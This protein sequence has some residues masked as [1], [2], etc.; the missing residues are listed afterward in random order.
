MVKNKDRWSALSMKERADLIKL[1]VSN[2]ITS[3]SNI[4]KDYNS[5]AP[6]GPIETGKKTMLDP[7]KIVHNVPAREW[8]PYTLNENYEL[9]E[10]DGTS[11]GRALFQYLGNKGKGADNIE[12]AKQIISDFEK[13]IKGNP[14]YN[15]VLDPNYESYVDAIH[16]L[17]HVEGLKK[18]LGLPYNTK[19]IVESNYK[20]TRLQGTD[21]KTYKFTSSMQP[22]Y[23]DEV[24][25]DMLIGEHSKRQYE[26]QTLN[27]FTAYRDR[28]N[29]GDFISIYDEWDYNPAVRG[30]NKKFNKVIDILTGG[31]P[32][33]VYDR[34]Y[35]DDYFNI[36]EEARGNP[37]ITPAVVTAESKKS[38]GGKLNRFDIGGPTREMTPSEATA[39][40]KTLNNSQY[41]LAV[42]NSPDDPAYLSTDILEPAIVKAFNSEED[43]NRYYGEQFGKKV[44][45]EGMN[46]AAPF[47]LDA[48]ML[49]FTISGAIEAPMLLYQGVKAAPQ[50][51]R[52]AKTLLTKGKKSL[53]KKVLGMV[54]DMN[55]YVKEGSHFRIVDKPA[56]DDAISSGTIR[57]K[58]GLYHGVPEYLRKNFSK[59]LDD[60]PGWES[61]DANDLKELLDAK[62]AFN[63][64]TEAEKKIAKFKIG[65]STN[66]GG[67]VGYFKDTPYPNY[68]ISNSNYVIETPESIGSFV[69]GHG[70][71]EFVDIPLEHA[72]ATL[73]KTN[74][75]VKG[76]SI[77]SKG[78]SYWEYS[79][80][81]E[82]WKNK[83]FATG[84]PT[85]NNWEIPFSLEPTT[86]P[87]TKYD[88]YTLAPEA[89][90]IPIRDIKKKYAM[91]P[92]SIALD[93]AAQ[94]AE[95]KERAA[96][97][98]SFG[99]LS[100]VL[101]D[102]GNQERVNKTM[103][104]N[105]YHNNQLNNFKYINSS[106]VDTSPKIKITAP[107]TDI[108]KFI[109]GNNIS[110]EAIK[111]IKQVAS[112]RNLDPYDILAHMLIESSGGFNGITKNSYF[113]THDVLDRQISPR[114]LDPNNSRN[115][116]TLLKNLGV[117]NESRQYTNEEIRDYILDYGKQLQEAVSN[118]EY[119]SSTIDAVGLRMSKFGRDFNPAQKGFKSS[120]GEVKNS[121]LDMIDSAITSL[122]ENMPDLFK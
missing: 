84:G 30:G 92:A 33:V 68:N 27:T 109:Y 117:Y 89:V 91:A 49:P 65:N 87:I 85:E 94:I 20:P 74:G 108:S 15:I 90:Q 48:A 36:P 56:I 118:I 42:G 10:K 14:N 9:I 6:G 106:E 41:M 47:V 120:K 34:I 32:F 62:G 59:Y 35:L 17:D 51:V 25:D 13:K 66:H 79:P 50:L 98:Y 70:G 81:F 110:E 72:G 52:G 5:F 104:T 18:Y 23:W 57:S 1:Y 22:S 80:F 26:D 95:L 46:N 61:M 97:E 40:N 71:E 58:T 3:L 99:V 78:S 67:T 4:K 38:N 111:E 122:K 37:F 77:P 119:P 55:G 19:T 102:I 16:Y 31:K 21:E 64:M 63:G 93:E 7:Q 103:L 53:G 24:V 28:D 73:L 100:D 12:F 82:M 43:Y 39:L 107:N 54:D 114:L 113:N 112:K 8:G 75:S 2:G 45:V 96:K 83:K 101:N 44:V 11:M 60:I 105:I 121:Y 86:V 29:K 115:I 88:Y 69:A 116:E 76:A